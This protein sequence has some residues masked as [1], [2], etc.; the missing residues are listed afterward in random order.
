[1]SYGADLCP[2]GLAGMQGPLGKGYLPPQLRRS[3]EVNTKP[4]TREDELEL[5][6]LV[7]LGLQ[8]GEV[9]ECHT[10]YLSPW[11]ATPNKMRA[12]FVGTAAIGK[13]GSANMAYQQYRSGLMGSNPFRF[14]E[15]EYIQLFAGMTGINSDLL[16]SASYKHMAG[17]KIADQ[18][19]MLQ[20]NCYN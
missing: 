13:F 9:E 20:A 3:M 19:Q 4:W 7:Q 17:V 15:K 2:L 6:A 1:M 11:A 14:N 12:C 8:T 10:V 5:L 18:V 16:L